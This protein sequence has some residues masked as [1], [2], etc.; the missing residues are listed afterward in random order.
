MWVT[1]LVFQ[2]QHQEKSGSMPG[3]ASDLRKKW[4]MVNLA[5]CFRSSSALVFWL[6]MWQI[7]HRRI[8]SPS[9]VLCRV[10]A[11]LL[12]QVPPGLLP[13]TLQAFFSAGA[14]ECCCCC[15]LPGCLSHDQGRSEQGTGA[16]MRASPEGLPARC[17]FSSSLTQTCMYLEHGKFS[18]IG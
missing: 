7:Q 2:D 6:F 15:C 12:C 10:S 5:R 9:S 17:A 11:P 3:A 14:L 8:L 16:V 13:P 4:Q 18:L 1:G